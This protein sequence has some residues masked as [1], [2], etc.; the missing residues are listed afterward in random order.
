MLKR[1][2]M[3]TYHWLSPMRP[4]RYVDE[5]A[6]RYN[7][8]DIHMID[9]IPPGQKMWWRSGLGTRIWWFS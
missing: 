9:Q 4:G 8:L 1:A 6:G 7:D 3:G 2:Q 5:F